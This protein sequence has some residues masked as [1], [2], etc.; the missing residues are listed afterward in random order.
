MSESGIVTAP[1]ADEKTYSGKIT[2]LW[3]VVIDGNTCIFIELDTGN[4]LYGIEVKNNLNILSAAVGD[5]V[6]IVGYKT[7]NS[8][9]IE[10]SKIKINGNPNKISYSSYTTLETPD[11]ET[12][13]TDTNETK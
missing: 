2:N 10:I 8:D 7:E 11:A 4:G 9:V 3:D 13:E 1:P 5:N 12:N 6:E